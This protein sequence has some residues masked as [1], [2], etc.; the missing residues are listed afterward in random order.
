MKQV[1]WR[2]KSIK[3]AI[4]AN[5]AKDL[6]AGMADSEPAGEH[7]FKKSHQLKTCTFEMLTH[8]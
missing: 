6:M 1:I 5:K 3:S 2:K 7:F 8:R 4:P